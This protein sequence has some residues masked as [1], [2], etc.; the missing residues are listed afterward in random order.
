MHTD[1]GLSDASRYT[2]VRCMPISADIGKNVCHTISA[3]P[4]FA[5]IVR[6]WKITVSD[7]GRYRCATGVA[8]LAT[9][10]ADTK[11]VHSFIYIEES[12]N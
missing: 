12:N 2:S 10:E 9:N 11:P 4:T 3:G 8:T 1:I 7:I 6:Y 5:N